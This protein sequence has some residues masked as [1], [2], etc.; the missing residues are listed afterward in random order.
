MSPPS[1]RVPIMKLHRS[2]ANETRHVDGARPVRPSHLGARGEAGHL[3][4]FYE[5]DAFLAETVAEFV[6]DGLAMGQPALVVATPAHRDAFA[7]QLAA[8]GVDGDA[9]VARG[10]LTFLDAAD[11]I[12]A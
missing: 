12:A 2:R 10:R 9:L 3:V 11:T 6:R 1:S 4:Q 5:D 7:A 8:R